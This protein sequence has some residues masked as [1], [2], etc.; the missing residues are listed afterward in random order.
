MVFCPSHQEI[1]KAY[2]KL[3][4]LHHP[5]KNSGNE[6]SSRKFLEISTAFEVLKDEDKRS[7]YDMFGEKGRPKNHFGVSSSIDLFCPFYRRAP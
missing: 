2:K 4:L 5:D 3:A 6:E 7:E 1:K